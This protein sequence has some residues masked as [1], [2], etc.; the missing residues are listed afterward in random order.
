[1][2]TFPDTAAEGAM[3]VSFAV[4]E[5]A[6]GKFRTDLWRKTASRKLA[7]SQELKAAKERLHTEAKAG[8]GRPYGHTLFSIRRV[9]L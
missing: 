5:T 4:S 7:I 1:M 3:K 8:S 6:P 9:A 2:L